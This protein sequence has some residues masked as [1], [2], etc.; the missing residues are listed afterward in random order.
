M[1]QEAFSYKTRAE[2]KEMSLL[3]LNAYILD[4]RRRSQWVQGEARK[5]LEQLMEE[6]AKQREAKRA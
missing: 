6:A 5:A 2:L 4:L 3:E 1:A